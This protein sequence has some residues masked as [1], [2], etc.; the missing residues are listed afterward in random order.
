L[1]ERL[2]Y[3]GGKP[4]TFL[5]GNVGYIRQGGEFDVADPH[6]VPGFLRRPDVEHVS[7]PAGDPCWCDGSEDGPPGEGSSGGG[8]DD[9]AGPGT[10]QAGPAVT[11]PG[12]APPF[13]PPR[14]LSAPSTPPGPSPV[15]GG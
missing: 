6:L 11:A 4:V 14:P 7:C 12:A 10:P 3:T 9:G 15:P 13:T 1:S 2:R 5:S 8:S